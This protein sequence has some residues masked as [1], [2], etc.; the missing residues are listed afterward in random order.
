MLLVSYCLHN[1]K[2]RKYNTYYDIVYTQVRRGDG[3]YISRGSN[4]KEKKI[5]ISSNKG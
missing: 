3:N 1:Q 2:Q 4:P 5:L